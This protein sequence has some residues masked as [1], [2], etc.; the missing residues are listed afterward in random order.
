MTMITLD[1]DI[2]EEQNLLGDMRSLIAELRRDISVFR[3]KLAEGGAPSGPV[4]DVKQL[5]VLIR[6]CL[7]TETRLAKLREEQVGIAQNGIA[8]DL[9]AARASIGGKLDRLRAT[10]AAG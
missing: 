10:Q 4:P 8:F 3:T 1:T 6:N 9:D 5:G 2:T 7:D